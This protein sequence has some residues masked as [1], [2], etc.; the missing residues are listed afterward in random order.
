MYL[1]N[2]KYLLTMTNH[3]YPPS[4]VAGTTY[5]PLTDRTPYPSPLTVYD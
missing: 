3:D 1:N 2:K 4:D 5:S